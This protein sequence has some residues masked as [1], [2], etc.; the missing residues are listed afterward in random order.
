MKQLKKC[1]NC[2]TENRPEAKFCKH[3]GEALPVDDR[4]SEFFGKKNLEPV[5]E[6]FEGRAAVAAKMHKMGVKA[7][8]GMDALVLG[9]AGT[10]KKFVADRLF[11][12]LQREKLIT[13]SR[14]T[15]V[16]AA[17]MTGWMDAFDTNIEAIQGGVL[18]ITNAQKLVPGEYATSVGD[19]DKLFARMKSHPESTPVVI[20]CGLRKGMEEFLASNPD[21]ASVFEYRFDLKPM[22]EQD[23]CSLCGHKLKNDFHIGMG[24]DASDKLLKHLVWMNRE[25]EGTSGNGHVA[26]VLAQELAVNAVSCDRR[27]VEPC[28]ITG[29]VF[30][31][32]TEAEIWLELDGFI[33]MDNVKKEIH[34]II[35]GIREARQTD[36]EMRLEDHYVFT[37]NPGTGKTTIARIFADILGALGILPRGQFVEVAGK[38]LI[39]DIVGGSE[40][41]VQDAVDRAM[42]GVL[43]IDEAYALNQGEFGQAAID[44]LL[45]I[46]ENHRGEFVCILAGYSREMRE[47]MKANSGLQSRFNKAIDFPDYNA[48]ELERIFRIMASKKGYTLDPEADS[49]LH[50]EMEKIYNRRSENFG[51]ARDIRNFLSTAEQRRRE[52]LRESDGDMTAAGR[53]LTYTDIA[54]KDA[55]QEVCLKDVMAELDAL[56]GLDGVKAS[57]RR[58]AASVNRELKLAEAE[59]R[60]PDVSVGHYL[61]LGNPGTGKTTVARLMGKMLYAMKL[62]PRPD[63]TEVLRDDLIAG[64]LGQTAQK[65][66]DAVMGAMGGVLF[67][68]EAYSLCT[69]RND[70]FGQECINTLVPLLENYKGKFVCIAAGYSREMQDFLDANSGMKSRFRNRIDFEDYNPEQMLRIFD[71]MCLKQE[72][73]LPD[74]SREAVR[75]KLQQ[76]YDNRKWDFANAREVR[77]L[78]D[79]IKNNMAMRQLMDDCSDLQELKTIKP[80]DVI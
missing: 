22:S 32:R 18:I 41:N 44:K 17:D 63:V 19:L 43:F 28:D 1:S 11:G 23:I 4:F 12:I 10:G 68:D 75:R 64:Y 38:D 77:N 67:I 26:D 5:F 59:G 55:N 70:T 54:G 61:F 60:T 52:R 35:D 37:G 47:F 49:K 9:D 7:R 66:K 65:T 33:G 21:A 46:L 58:L 20:M 30:E 73:I 31:P 16:D 29:K 2:N 62:I 6:K 13:G 80:E 8:V 57:I 15:V 14:P 69:D 74:E 78:M 3:C 36:S 42:G 53:V 24:G 25:G 50:M 71:G 27:T 76:I 40:R 48:G 79:D 45:P 56:T 72:L 51:N 39:A 34:S